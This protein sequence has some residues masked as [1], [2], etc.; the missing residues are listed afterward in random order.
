MG[1]TEQ[2]LGKMMQRGELLS[3]DFLPKFATEL[4]NTFGVAAVQAAEGP[5]AVF[6]RFDNVLLS[7]KN[8]IG[9]LL[10]PPLMA[11]MGLFTSTV[12]VIKE[13]PFI[14]ITLT[15][16]VAG[17]AIAV[18]AVAWATKIWAGFQWVLNAAMTANPIGLIIAGVAALIAGV[19]YAWNKFEGFR[20]V[21]MGVLEVGKLLSGVFLGLGKILIGGLTFNPA[22]MKEG[23]SQLADVGSQIANGGI[24]KAFNQGYQGEVG[25][26]R[27]AKGKKERDDMLKEFRAN[28]PS[29]QVSNAFTPTST[30]GADDTVKGITSGGPRVINI[31]IN[32][33]VEKLEVHAASVKEGMGEIKD[34]VEEA[35]LRVLYSGSSTQ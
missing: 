26:V 10:L 28:N 7:L 4:Q 3:K 12:D 8:T 9:V 20:G 2:Q 1:L 33:L 23:V 25:V 30:G 19:I 16:A 35:L 32:K 15:A 11:M 5:Q 27:A 14:F 29:A 21:L 13:Y 18:N 6:N 34:D 24:S 22:L 17:F 31:H